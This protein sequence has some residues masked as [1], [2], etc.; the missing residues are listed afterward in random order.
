MYNEKHLVDRL[1]KLRSEKE[2]SAREMSLALGQNKNYIASVESGHY[3]PSMTVFFY[4]CEY[5]GITPKEF[6][7]DEIVAPD[8][9]SDLI[10]NVKKLDR[11]QLDSLTDFVKNMVK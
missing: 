3:M 10:D 9:M 11:K 1:I 2:V 7:D 8:I 4:I 5:F 6:F